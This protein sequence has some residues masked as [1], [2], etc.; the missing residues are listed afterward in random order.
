M[1]LENLSVTG[2]IA[3]AANFPSG[4][5]GFSLNAV[6]AIQERSNAH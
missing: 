1:V 4:V 2:G 5:F 3:A 6:I